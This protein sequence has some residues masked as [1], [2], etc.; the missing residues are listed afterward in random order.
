MANFNKVILIGNLTR[1]PQLTYLPSNTPVVELGMAVNRT[2]RRQDGERGEE[3]CFVDLR[4]F[5]KRAEVINQYCHKG[6]P[7]MVEGRLHLDQWD[8]KQSGQKRSKMVVMIENFEFMGGRSGGGGDGG[9]SGGGYQGGGGGGGGYQG[10]GAPGGGRS[11]G[12]SGGGYQGGQPS[13]GGGNQG[14]P[15]EMGSDDDIPF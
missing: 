8:D 1:D 10:G 12:G 3:T 6:D 11:G 14:P 7:L 2:F 13:Q 5:G 4:M 15:P 9:S